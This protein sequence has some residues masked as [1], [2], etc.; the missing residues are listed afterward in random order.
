MNAIH[1]DYCDSIAKQELIANPVDSET[2]EA[3]GDSSATSNSFSGQSSVFTH[4][5]VSDPLKFCP[6]TLDDIEPAG[7]IIKFCCKHY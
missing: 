4:K 5:R 6:L 7:K 1:Q 3:Q 2:I